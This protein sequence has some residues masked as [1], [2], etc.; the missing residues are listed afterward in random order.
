MRDGASDVAHE[1]RIPDY[2]L[3]LT[4]GAERNH[5]CSCR[6]LCEACSFPFCSGGCGIDYGTQPR[7]Q[8]SPRDKIPSIWRIDVRLPRN[9]GHHN[10]GR[11]TVL[12]PTISQI[13]LMR[14]QTGPRMSDLNFSG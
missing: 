9:H 12:S 2:N 13:S 14:Q 7:G 5:S 3:E 11:A 4:A 6:G 8:E 10:C 1:A